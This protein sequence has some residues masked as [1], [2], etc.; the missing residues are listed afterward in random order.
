VI[1]HR[2]LPWMCLTI[3]GLLWNHS[4]NEFESNAI[5]VTEDNL[6]EWNDF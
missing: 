1:A 6:C 4:V 5:T 3:V 2:W